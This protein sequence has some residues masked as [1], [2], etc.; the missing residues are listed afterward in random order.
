MNNRRIARIFQTTARAKPSRA[1]SK[2]C[3]YIWHL[4]LM[5]ESSGQ[6]HSSAT[7]L[8]PASCGTYSFSL[9]WLYVTF[10]AF[11]NRYL[12]ILAFRYPVV[13]TATYTSPSQ[14]HSWGFLARNRALL[15]TVWLQSLCEKLKHV[16]M[17]PF[18]FVIFM[19]TKPIPHDRS[20]QVILSVQDVVWLF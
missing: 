8:S 16:S 20:C 14:L 19:P 4:G 2:C 13:S 1:N 12:N 18:S 17:V 3:L 5:M 9:R 6:S 15:H 7:F 10:A 11:R